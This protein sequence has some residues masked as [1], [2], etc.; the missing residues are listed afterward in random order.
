MG[1]VQIVFFVITLAV[2]GYFL[3]RTSKVTPRT[4]WGTW[5]RAMARLIDSD[6]GFPDCA[7]LDLVNMLEDMCEA[8]RLKSD[9]N[10]TVSVER[11]SNEVTFACEYTAHSIRVSWRLQKVDDGDLKCQDPGGAIAPKSPGFTFALDGRM[12]SMEFNNDQGER[13]RIPTKNCRAKVLSL[14]TVTPPP[15]LDDLFVKMGRLKD[16]PMDYINANFMC[17]VFDLSPKWTPWRERYRR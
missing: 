5:E 12:R 13:Q 2:P 1:A 10:T 16:D 17:F 11:S 3:T 9:K 14:A 15:E 4:Q 6:G 7:T 8:S